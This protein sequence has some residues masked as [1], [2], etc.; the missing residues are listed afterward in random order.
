MDSFGSRSLRV[1]AKPPARFFYVLKGWFLHIVVSKNRFYL[2]M[3]KKS[4]TFAPQRY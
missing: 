2:R 4:S 1:I 3:S